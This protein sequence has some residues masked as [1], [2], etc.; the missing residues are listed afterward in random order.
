MHVVVVLQVRPLYELYASLSHCQLRSPCVRI[1]VVTMCHY[2]ALCV[3][4]C[5]Y[6]SLCVTV[7]RRW[8]TGSSL[9]SCRSTT[10]TLGTQRVQ[11]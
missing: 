2:V 11:Q 4:M 1:S 10:T 7:R 6:V 3:P 9:S 8:G 5:H